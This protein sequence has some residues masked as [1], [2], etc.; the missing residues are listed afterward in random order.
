MGI[1]TRFSGCDMSCPVIEH[2]AAV[3]NSGKQLLFDFGKAAFAQVILQIAAV[4]SGK[5]TIE[6]GECLKAGSVD[7]AP[8][9]FRRYFRDE[10]KYSAGEYALEVVFPPHQAPSSTLKKCLSPDKNEVMPFRYIQISGNDIPVTAVSR[11]AYFGSFNDEAADFESSDEKLN[12]VWD[13][14]KY[15]IKATNAFECYIDGDRERLPYEGDAYINQLGHFCCDADYRKAFRTIDRLL[16]YPTWPIEW[17]LLMPVITRDYLLYSGDSSA[18][19]KWKAPLIK[20][21]F[22]SKL[23]DSFLLPERFDERCNGEVV[24]TIIDW[25]LPERDNCEFASPMTVPNCYLYEALRAMADLYHDNSFAVTAEKVRNAICNNLMKDGIFVDCAGSSHSSIH[26][27][28]FPVVFGVADTSLYPRLASMI[29]AKGMPCSVYA[30]QF[31]LDALFICNAPQTAIALMTAEDDRSWL[32]M[33]KQG[34]T[35]SMEA[36][37]NAAKPNQDWNHA[38]GAA[39]AN[40][41]PR[42]LAGIRPVAPGFS[43]F[44]VDPHPGDLEFFRY[45]Q[46]TLYGGITIEYC[47]GKISLT[48]PD[49]SVAAINSTPQIFELKK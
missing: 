49:G 6:V 14:C 13:F 41:I 26:T 47:K 30:A 27:L 20:S 19:D 18:L 15:S 45:R 28:A 46:P 39:P 9:G 23:D 32:G 12:Q 35:I 31:V 7:P 3:R 33:L 21:V 17:R 44:V 16:E 43:R 11:K 8:G 48:M 37:N 34:S 40:V 1:L 29:T 36:W 5:L 38:W 4:R 24:R 25:P 10:I 42:R 22:L 2:A